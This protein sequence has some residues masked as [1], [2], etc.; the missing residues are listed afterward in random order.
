MKLRL[1][2]IRVFCFHQVSDVFDAST[3][4][5]CDW[6][7]TDTF[8][9]KILAY[10]KD[11]EF[12]SL[13]EAYLHIQNDVYRRK[14][15]AVLTADDG[16]TSVTN[17][18]LWLVEQEIP[19]T[20]FVNSAYL[21]GKHYQERETEKLLTKAEIIELINQYPEYITI[22]SHGEKHI[23]TQLLNEQEFE[24]SVLKAETELSELPNKIP[25]YAFTYGKY[26]TEHKMVLAK[27]NI[28]PVLVDGAV[29][30]DNP[31]I[32][33]ECIDGIN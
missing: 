22:A 9:Q 18:I 11:Y 26:K 6:T 30:Y 1:Q 25:Y 14:K 24:S 3:M 13:E 17:I 12:I 16:W 28:V 10:K 19:I 2:P 33:R 20:L 5:E 7:Q 21:D 31:I 32:S 23:N 29:N 27:H 15:Y 4:W 8:K